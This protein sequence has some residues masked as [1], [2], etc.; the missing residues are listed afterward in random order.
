MSK[1]RRGF[2][3]R[4]KSFSVNAKRPISTRSKVAYITALLSCVC[5]AAATAYAVYTDGDSGKVAGGIGVVFLVVEIFATI[6]AMT[7]VRNDIEPLP[8][9]IFAVFVSVL[10][11]AAWGGLYMV[12]MMRG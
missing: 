6:S 5:F 8:A 11:L 2:F 3:G 10:A 1:R 12:G 4:R 9:R 7:Q